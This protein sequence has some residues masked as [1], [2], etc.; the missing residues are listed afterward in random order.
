MRRFLAIVV[1]LVALALLINAYLPKPAAEKKAEQVE[2][3][4]EAELETGSPP[5]EAASPATSPAA[6]G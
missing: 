4:G 3:P 2:A 6:G 5:A 1:A